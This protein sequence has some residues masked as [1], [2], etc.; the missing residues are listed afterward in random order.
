MSPPTLHRP[1]WCLLTR[2]RPRAGNQSQC[3]LCSQNI[4]MS[5]E[6]WMNNFSTVHCTTEGSVEIG[7]EW[8]SSL[9]WF[10]PM[11]SWLSSNSPSLLGDVL[12]YGDNWDCPQ[13]SKWAQNYRVFREAGRSLNKC[14]SLSP[15]LHS[16]NHSLNKNQGQ[17]NHTASWCYFTG[18]TAMKKIRLLPTKN[19]PF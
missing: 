3:W 1:P 14:I 11:E 13:K 10:P 7:Q 6:M 17:T 16:F 19:S 12:S 8:L 18:T 15:C 2:P 4:S 9:H 5:N